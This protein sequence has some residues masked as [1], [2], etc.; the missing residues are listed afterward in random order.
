MGAPA[1]RRAASYPPSPEEVSTS[2]NSGRQRVNGKNFPDKAGLVTALNDANGRAGQA[3]EVARRATQTAD[4]AAIRIAGLTAG[5]GILLRTV[6]A[7]IEQ[8]TEISDDAAAELAAERTAHNQTQR[9][10]RIAQLQTGYAE[11]KANEYAETITTLRRENREL[12]TAR[13]TE[14]QEAE[15]TRDRALR[16]VER[17]ERE[18]QNL[19]TDLRDIRGERDR[20]RHRADA[21]D[22]RANK[23]EANLAEEKRLREIA[24]KKIA[25][26]EQAAEARALRRATRPATDVITV[27]IDAATPQ[28]WY[29]RGRHLLTEEDALIAEAADTGDFTAVLATRPYYTPDKIRQKAAAIKAAKFTPDFGLDED[30]FAARLTAVRTDLA[31]ASNRPGRTLPPDNKAKMDDAHRKDE[32][33]L[34]AQQ[35]ALQAALPLPAWEVVSPPPATTI[36]DLDEATTTAPPPK[37]KGGKKSTDKSAKPGKGTDTP[38][39]A[40]SK[41]PASADLTNDAPSEAELADLEDLTEDFDWEAERA[42]QRR[43]AKLPSKIRV[44][45]EVWF[46]ALHVNLNEAT[47]LIDEAARSVFPEEITKNWESFRGSLVIKNGSGFIH[48][49]SAIRKSIAQRL[50]DMGRDMKINKADHVFAYLAAGFYADCTEAI[51]GSDS[52]NVQTMRES[53]MDYEA[54]HG[55]DK[56]GEL[57]KLVLYGNPQDKEMQSLY[58]LFIKYRVEPD[59]FQRALK[60]GK[61]YQDRHGD[62]HTQFMRNILKVEEREPVLV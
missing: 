50:S 31:E 26:L 41:Q 44:G 16:D 19:R 20:Q 51:E 33:T 17:L 46:A 55:F 36:I 5:N 2:P 27:R 3:E 42:R 4:N 40:A 15:R 28:P 6:D 1:D 53:L 52:P 9:Q 37:T 47:T 34:A 7:L 8:N 38:G 30:D 23:A 59:E 43:A 14:R 57:L 61:D 32:A 39:H 60:L 48:G 45:S 13:D 56:T 25:E 49:P 35:A 11:A 12:T 10:L 29:V 24:E 58:S 54:Q 22:K 62:V 18:K 21:S